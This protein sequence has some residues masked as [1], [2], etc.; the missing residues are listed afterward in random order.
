MSGMSGGYD[1][2]DYN[3]DGKVDQDDAAEF[4]FDETWIQNHS[5]GGSSG[6]SSGSS[7]GNSFGSRDDAAGCCYLI[8]IGAAIIFILCVIDMAL[9]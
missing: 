6:N 3:H 8:L 4:E 9:S 1:P 2:R 5:S 7:S